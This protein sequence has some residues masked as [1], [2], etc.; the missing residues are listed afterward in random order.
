MRHMFGDTAIKK[1][2]YLRLIVHLTKPITEPTPSGY[3][4]LTGD[5]GT[6]HVLDLDVP[7]ITLPVMPGRNLAVL[8]EAATRLHI[9]RTKGID[10]ATMFIARHSNL[11]ERRPP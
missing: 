3:E 4:R 1:N 7:L 6:R 10:P 9:L 8:T 5:S 11:L 2:K